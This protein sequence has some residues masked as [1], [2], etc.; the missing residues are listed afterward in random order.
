MDKV[1]EY[2]VVSAVGTDKFNVLVNQALKNGWVPYGDIST[3]VVPLS[4][5][6]QPLPAIQ[7]SQAMVK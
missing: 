7:Y 2:S 1:K 3:V 4:L 5:G 6:G